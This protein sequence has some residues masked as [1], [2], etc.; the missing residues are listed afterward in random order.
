MVVGSDSQ[1]RDERGQ[2]VLIAAILVAVTVL[3]A[4]V[5][6]NTVHSSPNVKA[7]TDAQSV[8]NAE[9]VTG[10]IQGDLRD[11]FVATNT[12]NNEQYPFVNQGGGEDNLNETLS[13]YETQFVEMLTTN[14]SALIDITYN[15]G[16][17]QTGNFSAGEFTASPFDEEVMEGAKSIPSLSVTSGGDVEIEFTFGGSGPTAKN[18]RLY[19]ADPKVNGENCDALSDERLTLDF[20][21]GSGMIRDESGGVCV[22]NLYDPEK[23]TNV[24]VEIDSSGS[25]SFALSGVDPATSDG[26]TVVKD[27]IVNP[28][29]DVEYIDPNVEYNSNFVLFGGDN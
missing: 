13:E 16:L 19:G 9:R 21:R 27:V 20:S 29:F 8:S 11:V 25:G 2:L 3:G 15:A 6:L 5:L 24:S 22:V 4:V 28:V 14:K 10:Q 18:V 12:T 23:V 26:D 1:P 7:Q 17:S